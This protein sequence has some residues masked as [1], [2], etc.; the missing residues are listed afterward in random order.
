MC[1]RV[2]QNNNI[3]KYVNNFLHNVATTKL[4]VSLKSLRKDLSRNYNY[5][6]EIIITNPPKEFF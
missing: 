3:F 6:S 1:V 2:S 4:K 5:E